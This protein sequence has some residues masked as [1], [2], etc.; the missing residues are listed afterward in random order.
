[1]FIDMHV[2]LLIIEATIIPEFYIF[3]KLTR[4]ME[5]TLIEMKI[6]WME[7]TAD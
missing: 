1:M 7:L 2:Y 6:N 4:D 5:I 3:K